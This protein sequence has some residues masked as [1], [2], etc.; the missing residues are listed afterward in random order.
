MTTEIKI[1][2]S[3]EQFTQQSVDKLRKISGY[4]GIREENFQQVLG[5]RIK[6]LIGQN[7]S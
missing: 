5:G 7:I 3:M 6:M 1:E 2:D 4:E